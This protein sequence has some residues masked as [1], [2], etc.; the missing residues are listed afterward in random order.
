VSALY[1]PTTDHHHRRAERVTRVGGGFSGG[2]PAHRD[3]VADGAREGRVVDQHEPAGTQPPFHRFPVLVVHADG[4][5]RLRDDGRRLDR[6]VSHDHRAVG[7]ATAHHAAVQPEEEH[8]APLERRGA[9]DHLGGELHAL[10]AD[11]RD[12]Q[13]PFHRSSLLTVADGY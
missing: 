10:P 6:F 12:E 11:A 3:V 8:L 4:G 5:P 9:S 2:Q 1:T 13:F 7:V